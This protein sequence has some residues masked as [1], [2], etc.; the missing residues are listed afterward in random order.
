MNFGHF[1]GNQNYCVTTSSQ[2]LTI[3]SID[4]NLSVFVFRIINTTFEILFDKNLETPILR[5]GPL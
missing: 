3:T 4:L 2:K 5:H 1:G